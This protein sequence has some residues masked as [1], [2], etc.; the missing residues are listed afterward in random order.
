MGLSDS[1]VA[2]IFPGSVVF[3]GVAPLAFQDLDLSSTIGGKKTVLCISVEKN[4]S[5][6]D[7]SWFF[8][9]KGEALATGLQN[10]VYAC[11]GENSLTKRVYVLCHT[12]ASG[13]IEWYGSTNDSVKLT[14]EW[15]IQ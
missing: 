5:T 4:A 8:R 2:A 14:L 7:T 10:S 12:N 13:L 9:P 1:R 6:A 11:R 15:Y 3:N